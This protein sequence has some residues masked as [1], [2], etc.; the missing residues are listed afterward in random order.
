MVM[1]FSLVFWEFSEFYAFINKFIDFYNYY[2]KNHIT[3]KN[4]FN[5]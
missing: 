3:I 1:Y 5:D 2:F 4:I